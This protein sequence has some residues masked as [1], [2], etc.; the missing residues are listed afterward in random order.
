MACLEI[1]AVPFP[2]LPAPL[3]LGAALPSQSFDPTLCCKLLPFPVVAPPVTLGVVL[4]GAI[5]VALNTQ[6]A[7]MLAY[8][9]ARPLNCPYE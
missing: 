1:P 3:T 2:E 7:L 9:D 4:T 8:F 5:V 6:M